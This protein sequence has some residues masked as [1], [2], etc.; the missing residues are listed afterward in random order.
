MFARTGS[1][2]RGFL[3]SDPQDPTPLQ[4]NREQLARRESRGMWFLR[5]RR[6]PQ[7]DPVALERLTDT[8]GR[9]LVLIER[10][11]AS[12]Q[13][14]EA[15][16]PVK[17]VISS[18]RQD[19]EE[20]E[21]APQHEP[22]PEPP[23][24]E[25]PLPEPPLPELPPE[26]PP[27]EPEPEHRPAAAPEQSTAFVLFVPTPAGYRV[28]TPEGVVPARGERLRVEE[29]WYR[30]VRLGPSPLPGDDSRCVFLEA[31]EATLE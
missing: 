14:E 18:D 12:R 13:P 5:R 26:P 25:P 4:K 30:V 28:A 3:W 20:P 10:R 19:D 17:V 11:L 31:D 2:S 7:L 1:R 27:P 6:R 21:D 24:P 8:I 29:R 23:P 15:R 9:V 22:S 16:A